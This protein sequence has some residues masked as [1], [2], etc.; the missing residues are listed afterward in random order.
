MPPMK[1]S[2]VYLS[3]VALNVQGFG[4]RSNQEGLKRYAEGIKVI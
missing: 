4:E 2:V 3:F 1:N